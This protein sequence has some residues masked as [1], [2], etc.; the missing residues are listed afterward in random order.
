VENYVI[1][2]I[3]DKIVNWCDY[4]IKKDLRSLKYLIGNLNM[5]CHLTIKEDDIYKYFSNKDINYYS[6][7]DFVNDN[8]NKGNN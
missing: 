7:R 5:D 6:I 3:S 2:I 1:N 4:T 8:L